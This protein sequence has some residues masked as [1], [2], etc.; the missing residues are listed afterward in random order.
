M[1]HS[2]V[3]TRARAFRAAC[4]ASVIT[5]AVALLGCEQVFTY[6]PVAFLQRP[7]SA[8]SAA[9]QLEYAQDALASGDKAAMTAAYDILKTQTTN[10]ESQYVAAQLG[11]ELSGVSELFMG[12]VDGSVTLTVGQS[13]DITGFLADHPELEPEYLIQAAAYMQNAEGRTEGLTTLD[14]VIGS[15][16]MALGAAEQPDGTFDFSAADATMLADAQSFAQVALTNTAGLDTT[17]PLYQFVDGYVAYLNG[18]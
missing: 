18:L 7:P 3:F 10:T 14:Y 5:V 4:M 1:N 17:D 8:L 11:V 9:Q 6:S 13:S 2:G 12:V 16:G 15:L